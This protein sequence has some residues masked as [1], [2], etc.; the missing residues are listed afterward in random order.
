MGGLAALIVADDGGPSLGVCGW[1]LPGWLPEV[2]L[3]SLMFER[4]NIVTIPRPEAYIRAGPV[5]AGANQCDVLDGAA[6]PGGPAREVVGVQRQD[7]TG[8]K[9]LTRREVWAPREMQAAP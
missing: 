1:W 8:V 7:R 3:V 4:P 9:A 2:S 5:V 6:N